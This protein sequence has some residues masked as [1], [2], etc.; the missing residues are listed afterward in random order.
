MSLMKRPEW[1]LSEHQ[2]IDLGTSSGLWNAGTYGKDETRMMMYSEP[3]N[4]GHLRR[5]IGCS[6]NAT[7]A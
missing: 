4:D 2:R 5:D 3:L 1:K 6:Q 7:V